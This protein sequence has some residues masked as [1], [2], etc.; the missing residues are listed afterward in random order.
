VRNA[1]DDVAGTGEARYRDFMSQIGDYHAKWR[2][3]FVPRIMRQSKMTAADYDQIPVF[4]YVAEAEGRVRGRV[5]Q[6]MAGLLVP[7]AAMVGVSIFLIA[8]YRIV[9]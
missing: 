2:A 8:R 4:R 3:F 9:R 6:S 7:L 1:L 5:W